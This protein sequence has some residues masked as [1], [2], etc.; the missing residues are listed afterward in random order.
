MEAVEGK[1][2]G[3]GE[4]RSERAVVP[5]VSWPDEGSGGKCPAKDPA[6]AAAYEP[7]AAGAGAATDVAAVGTGNATEGGTARPAR[8]RG[9]R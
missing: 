1:E 6:R 5:E 2:G 7:T 8:A 9:S 3:K 4:P